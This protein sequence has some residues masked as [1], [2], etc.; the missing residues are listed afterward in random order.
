MHSD[1]REQFKTQSVL[2]LM[3]A[4]ILMAT[5]F[6][7]PVTVEKAFAEKAP[8]PVA[9]MLRRK[10]VKASYIKNKKGNRAEYGKLSGQKSKGYRIFQGSCSDGKY[11]YHVL[12]NK[13]KNTCKVIKVDP[14]NHHVIKVSPAY[15]MY[16][17]NDIA[18]DTK[19][20]RLVIVHGDGDT[21]RLSIMNPKTLKRKKV[22]S[23][24]FSRAFK[25]AGKKT[26]RRIKG[27]TGIAYDDK[28]DQFICSVKSTFHYVVLNKKFKPVKFIRTKTRGKL[29]KQGMLIVDGR[30]LRV[31]NRY[32][33]K[34]VVGNYI[35]SYSRKGTLKK[36]IRI[37]T[38]SEVES[39]YIHGKKM[40]AS[41]YVEKWKKGKKIKMY[42]YILK[43][44]KA[45]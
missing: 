29:Q 45:G 18:Y 27:V 21:K 41:T 4:T 13:K 30:I 25:G 17:G 19:R 34:R 6:A 37:A 42:S 8:K 26:A 11:S 14:E 39:I 12:Y 36:R 33:G 23:L 22:V 7:E 5:F 3:T 31:M 15:K 38:G 1:K 40:Y 35:Y 24:R 9:S 43:L 44:R 20:D 2:V 32:K 16:H 28:N 10:T